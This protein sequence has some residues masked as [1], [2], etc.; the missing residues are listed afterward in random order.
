MSMRI[1]NTVSPLLLVVFAWLL[2]ACQPTPQ[3]ARHLGEEQE[4]DSALLARLQFNIRLSD[5]ADKACS[6][7]VEADTLR[8][9][10]DDFG[11]W[12][13]KTI[14]HEGEDLVAGQEVMLHLQISELDGT[15][16]TDTKG[17]FVIGAGDLPLVVIRSLRMMVQGEQMK[18]IAP[19]YTAYGVEGTAII[20][21]YHRIQPLGR[22][23]TGFAYEVEDRGLGSGD[24][25]DTTSGETAQKH[26]AEHTKSVATDLAQQG[27]FHIFGL[28]G[29][30]HE[31]KHKK[32]EDL[33]KYVCH[34][35]LYLPLYWVHY[36]TKPSF[37][38]P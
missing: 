20:K 16:I 11:F 10:L 3:R 2:V 26:I 31:Q 33:R 36:T 13:A 30:K 15:L 4:V 34:I 6:M 18:V 29:S 5:A 23:L 25:V 35:P 24:Q 7:M 28:R 14:S 22:F 32:T 1:G 9:E 12:Y 21:P 27:I 8:Y 19:W 38:Q 37:F 17:S